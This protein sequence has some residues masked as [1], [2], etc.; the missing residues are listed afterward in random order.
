MVSRAPRHTIRVRGVSVWAE[1]GLVPDFSVGLR[2]AGEVWPGELLEDGRPWP[3]AHNWRERIRQWKWRWHIWAHELEIKKFVHG[4]ARAA[5]YGKRVP[6]PADPVVWPDEMINPPPGMGRMLPAGT[7][8]VQYNSIPPATRPEVGVMMRKSL[9]RVVRRPLLGLAILVGA[10]S[11]SSNFGPVG[12]IA[13]PTF[14]I[15]YF[16]STISRR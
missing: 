12:I 9:W 4:Y 7:P 13:V 3:E 10:I 16:L 1:P 15:L 8:K 2:I 5:F 14:L 6:H 11:F